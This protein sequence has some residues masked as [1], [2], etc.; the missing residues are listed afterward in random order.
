MDQ[1]DVGTSRM[2]FPVYRT[3]ELVGIE[4]RYS[5]GSQVAKNDSQA[6]EMI[7]N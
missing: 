4:F 3:V 5:G 7:V 6:A 1:N 2:K